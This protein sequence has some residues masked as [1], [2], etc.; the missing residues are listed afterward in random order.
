MELISFFLKI[1]FKL[2]NHIIERK[3][4]YL[5]GYTDLGASSGWG[6]NEGEA[7]SDKRGILFDV[8]KV[9]HFI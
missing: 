2:K 9:L 1:K 3:P 6:S 4:V 8:K 7:M 5:S